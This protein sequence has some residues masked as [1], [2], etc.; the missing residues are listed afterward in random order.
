MRFQQRSK[1]IYSVIAGAMLI[2]L[3]CTSLN[4][5]L[6]IAD[7][8]PVSR[9]STTIEVD[10][11]DRVDATVRMAAG[12]LSVEG[13]ADAL[14]NAD[15]TYNVADWEPRVTYNVTDN[16]GR[17]DIR[18]AESNA[19]PVMDE[20]RNEWD[21]RLNDDV[22][23]DLRIEVGAGDHDLDLEGLILTELD[24]K[25][26]AGEMN[27]TLGDN[28]GLD[29]IDLDVGAGDVKIDLSGLWEG[30]AVV[31]IQGGVGKT[32]LYLP[33]AVGVRL[34]VTQG[35]GDLDVSGL[36]REGGA[37]INEAYGES[38]TTLDVDIQA[39]IGEIEVVSD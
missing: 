5:G 2:T 9:E 38:D 20:A 28:K 39:G 27:L 7:V 6:K 17:L 24:V 37:W 19:L 18:H 14:L 23:L 13:R 4:I 21:L 8:G 29:R 12:A 30:D 36:S 1:L 22:P 16:V 25:L 11:A 34:S 3:G 32:T 26:G 10:D 33:Q 31:S 15:F 35:I